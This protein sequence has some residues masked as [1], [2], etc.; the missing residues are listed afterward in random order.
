MKETEF[1]MKKSVVIYK[2]SNTDIIDKHTDSVQIY[3]V[4]STVIILT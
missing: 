3:G 2:I 4:T 1:I